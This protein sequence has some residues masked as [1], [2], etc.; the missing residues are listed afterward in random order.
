MKKKG[1][2]KGISVAKTHLGRENS[3]HTQ[4]FEWCQCMLFPELNSLSHWP[5]HYQHKCHRF[6]YNNPESL[7]PTPNFEC[8]KTVPCTCEWNEWNLKCKKLKDHF[9][10]HLVLG[11]NL[12]TFLYINKIPSKRS[13]HDARP[14]RRIRLNISLDLPRCCSSEWHEYQTIFRHWLQFALVLWSVQRNVS[15]TSS[16]ATNWNCLLKKLP[17]KIAK[18]YLAL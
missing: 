1:L 18:K 10:I 2:L 5:P 15:A 7:D 11:L 17:I 13:S 4:R 9:I 16:N 3:K 14:Y 8:A 6:D 12:W